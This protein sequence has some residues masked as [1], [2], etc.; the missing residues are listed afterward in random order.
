MRLERFT[1]KFQEAIA[2]AQSLALGRDH[3]FI[4]PVHLMHA[5]LNQDGGSVRD[6]LSKIGVNL[7]DLR[8]KISQ[9]IERLPQVEGTGGNLQLS[10]AM[11][12]L[13]NL[14]DKLA[15]KRKD[16]FISS[17]LFVLAACEDAGELGILLRQLGVHKER[18]ETA[19]DQLRGG[20]KVDDA[21][22][23]DT[24]QALSKYT[25]DLTARAEAGKLDPVI[26]RDI[27]VL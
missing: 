26:G 13:F 11:I 18:V 8:S 27:Q 22:A 2:T 9:A 16:Q 10:S 4:E 20:Q 12:N 15:Q 17:E 3:Q 1:S 24:R 7:H 21:N 14:C 5:M 19:I 25:I 23:E 6:L